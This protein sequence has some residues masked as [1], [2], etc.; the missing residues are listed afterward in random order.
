MSGISSKA[1]A[2]G[3]PENR[4][5]FNSIEYESDLE[6]NVYDAFYRELDPSIG[7][8]WEIDPKVGDM[9]KWSPYAENFD[10]PISY[11]DPLGDWPIL[12]ILA[13]K[14]IAYASKTV[15]GSYKPVSREQALKLLKEGKSVTQTNSDKTNKAAKKLMVEGAEGKKVVRHDGQTLPDGKTGKPHYQKK[16][17]DGSHV[18]YSS[19]VAALPILEFGL[20]LGTSGPSTLIQPLAQSIGQVSPNLKDAY[21]KVIGNNA[22][23]RFL[24]NFI[25][26]FN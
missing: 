2:F 16:S 1:L 10:N 3:G 6:V 15:K 26:P 4:Y 8:W 18:F 9:E 25:N 24:D 13:K 21:K 20:D 7:R 19:A 5:K 23:G 17:G 22:V 12:K 11:A 14:G